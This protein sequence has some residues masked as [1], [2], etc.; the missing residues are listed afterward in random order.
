MYD[1][2][3]TSKTL[4]ANVRGKRIASFSP[5]LNKREKSWRFGTGLKAISG[6]APGHAKCLQHE[7]LKRLKNVSNGCTIYVVCL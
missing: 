1:V 3:V 7:V 5:R 4:S 2:R 6:V